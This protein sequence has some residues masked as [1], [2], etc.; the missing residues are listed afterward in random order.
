MQF[1]HNSNSK[2][3]MSRERIPFNSHLCVDM[4]VNQDDLRDLRTSRHCTFN[5]PL[6]W[7]RQQILW[8]ER[9]LRVKWTHEW[10]LDE[11]VS[12]LLYDRSVRWFRDIT[13]E[14]RLALSWY[15]NQD[16][17]DWTPQRFTRCVIQIVHE[18]P[19]RFNTNNISVGVLSLPVLRYHHFYWRL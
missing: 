16:T 5:N 11:T 10:S 17:F 6:T 1:Y 12:Q 15:T 9:V 18:R 19:D 8:S 14:E 3:L 13:D 4:T 7:Y 2:L